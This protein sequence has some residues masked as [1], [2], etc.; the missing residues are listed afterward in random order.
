MTRGRNPSILSR[1]ERIIRDPARG[2]QDG[3][4]PRTHATVSVAL[5]GFKIIA[6][7]AD[8]VQT[9]LSLSTRLPIETADVVHCGMGEEK[10]W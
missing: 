10:E 7:R 5:Y 2:H 3:T 6:E 4:A 8:E 1:A 9:R